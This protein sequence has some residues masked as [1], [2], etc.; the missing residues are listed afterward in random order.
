M[1]KDKINHIFAGA[2]VAAFI[3]LPA[4]LESG[5]LFAGLWTA[6]TGGIIAGVVKELCDDNTD[7]NNWDWHDLA[8]TAIGVAIVAV[9][10]ILL[11]FG[12]G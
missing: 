4:Y 7:G 11:H 1:K 8:A 5:N 2:M 9:F 6:I 12:K 10:I 3:G